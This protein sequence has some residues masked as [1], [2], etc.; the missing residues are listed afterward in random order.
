MFSANGVGC[1]GENRENKIL[2]EK[3][4]NTFAALPNKM[5]RGLSTQVPFFIRKFPLL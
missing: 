3:S 5:F 2:G 4:A 1:V